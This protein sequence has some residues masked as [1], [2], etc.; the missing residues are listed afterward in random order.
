MLI[1][2]FGKR[3]FSIKNLK[4]SNPGVKVESVVNTIPDSK[5]PYL[6][7]VG[8]TF[9]VITRAKN[10]A[11]VE[12]TNYQGLNQT[13]LFSQQLIFSPTMFDDHMPGGYD[14]IFDGWPFLK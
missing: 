8:Q 14:Y 5:E 4:T 2:I 3:Y 11:E 9:L 7:H 10:K 12:V 13:D 6:H 1:P